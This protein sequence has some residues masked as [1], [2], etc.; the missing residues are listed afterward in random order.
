M[1]LRCTIEVIAEWDQAFATTIEEL[2]AGLRPH[3]IELRAGPGGAVLRAGRLLGRISAWD[4][5][6]L[7][8]VEWGP[9]P[10]AD[11][12]PP[13]VLRYTFEET[14][15]GRTRVT[16]EV[17][18][19]HRVLGEA[20]PE[21]LG[22]FAREML[23]PALLRLE[24]TL[25]GDW[26]TD[27]LAR[28][29]TGPR[30][31][32]TYRDPLYHRPNFLAILEALALRPDD[33]LVEIGCGGGAFL[34]DALDSGCRAAAIDHSPEM[35]ELAREVN[36][37][38]IQDRRLTVD[39]GKAEQLPFP[40]GEFTCAVSTGVLWFLADPSPFFREVHRVLRRGGRLALFTV[41][42]LLAGTVAGAEPMTSRS[43]YYSDLELESL[44][45]AAGF[46]D[47]RVEHP[48]LAKFAQQAALPQ[49]VQAVF[50]EPG[51]EAAQLLLA[52]KDG[53]PESRPGDR[54][55]GTLK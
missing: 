4:P 17:H 14:D 40:D 25:L 37:P 47:V 32:E 6:R 9:L 21:L 8:E 41:N 10:W 13:T 50:S 7:L 11:P 18:E 31:R 22:W 12:L 20:A 28:R 38:A 36:S 3:G 49:E 5:P 16:F 33:Y 27:R 44:A 55:P 48:D 54:A 46:T 24:P 35:V 29:P 15:P 26:I 52:R 30:A 19:P 45:R 2:T 53:G 51:S 23:A 1:T 39:V 34:H 42:E 43:R